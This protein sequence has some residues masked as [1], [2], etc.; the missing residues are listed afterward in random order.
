MH[1]RIQVGGGRLTAAVIMVGL[2]V[3]A[4]A[5]AAPARPDVTTGPAANV[6]Q[7]TATLTGQP[8]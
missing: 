1:R 7:T 3:P 6:G 4:A 8:Y 5:A 2:L